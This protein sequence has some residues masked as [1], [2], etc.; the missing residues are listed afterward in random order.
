[1]A[2]EAVS[3]VAFGSYIDDFTAYWKEKALKQNTMVVAVLAVGAVAILII[4]RSKG[5]K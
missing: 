3:A 1:M 4:T 2:S 5:P